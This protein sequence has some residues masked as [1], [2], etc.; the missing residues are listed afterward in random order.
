MKKLISMLL[1][2]SILWGFSVTPASFAS[3][4]NNDYPIVFLHGFAGWG[5]NELA[6]LKYWGG[7]I[8]LEQELKS[9]GYEAYTAVVGPFSSNWDRACEFYAYIKGGRVDYGA[10]HSEKYGHE[11]FG[12]TFPGLYSQWGE[13][14][15]SVNKIHI[16]AHSMGA[17][18][19]RLLVQLLEEGY[20]EEITAILGDNP[21]QE[22]IDTAIASN[23]LS[24]LFTGNCNDWVASVSSF[25]GANDGTTLADFA[26]SASGDL[27]TFFATPLGGIT[28]LADISLYDLKLDHWGLKRNTG[29]SFC[30]YFNRVM[31]SPLWK[32]TKDFSNYDLSTKGATEMNSWVEDQ[33]NVYYFSYSCQATTKLLIT[34]YHVPNLLYMN[35]AFHSTATIMG[36]YKNT[37]T[38]IDS[39]W[40]ANDGVVNT[41]SQS[42][43]KLGRSTNNIIP[44]NESSPQKGKWNHLG[45]NKACDH[46]DIIGIDFTRPASN[47]RD[48]YLDY[49][50]MLTALN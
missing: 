27:V 8:D 13:N 21:T 2:L 11:R 39:S 4:K 25:A 14:E 5:R 34:G 12:K 22:E 36:S 35:P 33:P 30:N 40:Y 15:D 10:A 46:G 43:P 47:M 48:Y 17:P 50:K 26:N 41:I 6:G 24:P 19:A 20:N 44:Y 31:G 32:T 29:E 9:A 18:T 42:G 49:A 23:A 7:I 3:E 45:V 38:G 1:C 37:S 28:G 16:V